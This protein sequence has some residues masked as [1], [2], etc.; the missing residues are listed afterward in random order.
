[1][2]KFVSG[3]D[4]VR[5]EDPAQVWW[6]DPVAAQKN[7]LSAHKPGPTAVCFLFDNTLS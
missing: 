3:K 5:C 4:P 7:D 2:K 1:M 6:I